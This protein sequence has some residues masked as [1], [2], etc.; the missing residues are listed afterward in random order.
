MNTQPNGQQSRIEKE[1]HD[2][3]HRGNQQLSVE[4]KE[5]VD[6]AYKLSVKESPQVTVET[7]TSGSGGPN[8]NV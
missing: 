3:I 2:L 4:L 1:R 5:A 7:L 6:L 8:H